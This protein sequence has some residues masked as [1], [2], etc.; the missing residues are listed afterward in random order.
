[1]RLLLLLLG[2]C[3]VLN[4]S[5]QLSGTIVYEEKLTIDFGDKLDKV[6]EAQR[7]QVMAMLEKMKEQTSLKELVFS[8][9]ACLYRSKKAE[10]TD[11][12]IES[13]GMQMK[14]VSS[15]SDQQVYRNLKENEMIEQTEFLGKQFLIEDEVETLPWKIETETKK[16]AGYNCQK[17][18][19]INEE[20]NDTVT[21]WFTKQLPIPAGPMVYGQLP[22]MILEIS[23]QQGNFVITATAVELAAIDAST[24]AA[25]TAGD[26]VSRKKY[27]KIVKAKMAEMEEYSGGNGSGVQVDVRI[28]R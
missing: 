21:A 13:D 20:K 8:P 17:A 23:Q 22:G 1:M 18:I 3:F 5:A 11:I 24:L 16:I 27:E 6:P 19:L 26:K 12:D 14:M 28:E 9:E 4:A 7:E 10:E 15:G 25:P 2:T